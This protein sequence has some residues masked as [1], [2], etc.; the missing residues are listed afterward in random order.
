[1][2]AAQNQISLSRGVAHAAVGMVRTGAA[3]AVEE[4]EGLR[5]RM[6]A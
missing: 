3:A 2:A 5:H 4:A 1:M 6:V